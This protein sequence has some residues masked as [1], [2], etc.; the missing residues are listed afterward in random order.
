MECIPSGW[1]DIVAIS[2][3]A[4]FTGTTQSV[5][6]LANASGP[7]Q[8]LAGK[9]GRAAMAYLVAQ[10]GGYSTDPE[11]LLKAANCFVPCLTTGLR[12]WVLMYLWALNNN[13]APNS[14]AMLQA[15]AP[16]QA[17][18]GQEQPIILYLLESLDGNYSAT[19]AAAGAACFSCALNDRQLE[20]V[21]IYLL[22]Q[23]LVPAGMNIIPPGSTYG[24]TGEFDIAILPNTY[25]M[26]KWG[27]N[28]VSATVCGANYT[29]G[30][31]GTQTIFY[32]ASC[33]LLQ[34]FGNAAG[35]FVTALVLA[36]HNKEAPPAAFA[37]TLTSSTVAQASWA[38]PPVTGTPYVVNTQVWTSTDGVNYSLAG[39]VAAPGTTL[40]VTAPTLGNVLYAKA[41]WIY[42]DGGNGGF[43]KPQEVFG[44]VTDWATRVVTN[45]GA[46]V[47]SATMQAM[48]TF[49]GALNA[50]GTIIGKIKSMV[51][52]TPGSLIEAATPLIK[53]F[54]T[55]PWGQTA[56]LVLTVNG[57]VATVGSSYMTPGITPSA[58][59]SSIN[60]GGLTAYI[61]TTTN[62]DSSAVDM[63]C[64]QGSSKYF[65]LYSNFFA[66]SKQQA[67]GDFYSSSNYLGGLT[68]PG[69]GFF[70][71]N[72][73]GGVGTMYVGSSS[74][75]GVVAGAFDSGRGGTIPAIPMYVMGINSSGITAG[76]TTVRRYSFFCIHDGFTQT[77]AKALFNAVQALR[78]ALGGGYV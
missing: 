52:I 60:N 76:T 26:I 14:T 17:V 3:L 15:A 63:G 11:T 36:T 44:A 7:Y 18:M 69:T 50:A 40:N 70:S 78:V 31:A 48:N 75:F 16:Y 22:C 35:T 74:G 12:R 6:Q 68:S 59:F 34:L 49:Y 53:T 29:S 8:A 20:D 42:S 38:S 9:L 67:I 61:Y 25:Y 1:L 57:I 46:A 45:G 21:L 77:E 51:C 27:A 5:S 71:A 65:A 32:S 41:L 28:D 56:N 43:T 37:F 2:Q 4:T 55:D 62:G 24:P 19:K 10:N 39:T 23:G 47:S 64:N 30:G 73:T 72:D 33:T 13:M 54:G 58:V 66:A